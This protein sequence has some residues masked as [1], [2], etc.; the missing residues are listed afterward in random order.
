M[1]QAITKK[2]HDKSTYK[3]FGFE[4]YCDSCNVVWS[5][6]EYSFSLK[7]DP[8]RDFEEKVARDII[9]KQE[10]DFAYERANIECILHFNKCK[11]CGRRVCDNCYS[12][13]GETCKECELKG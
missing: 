6:E 8:P 5:S 4:F 10:H 2:Y 11:Q 12:E 1:L 13:L 3:Y 7:D 9:W